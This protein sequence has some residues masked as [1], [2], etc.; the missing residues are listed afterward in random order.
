[1]KTKEE[2]QIAHD[3]LAGVMEMM[4]SGKIHPPIPAMG[5]LI[6]AASLD[7]LCW[8]LEHPENKFQGLV[9]TLLTD[10]KRNGVGFTPNPDL[11]GIKTHQ[12]EGGMA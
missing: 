4:A 10:L 8:A 2:M 1:M 3:M 12:G 7:V 11:H 9:D 6:L 5:M